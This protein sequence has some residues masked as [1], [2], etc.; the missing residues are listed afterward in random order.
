[1]SES[2][3]LD[4]ISVYRA[5]PDPDTTRVPGCGKDF[6][7]VRIRQME[8]G[9]FVKFAFPQDEHHSFSSTCIYWKKK[10]LS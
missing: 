7:L 6:D 1:M 10:D 2:S 8:M 9:A 3:A 4:L 5:G